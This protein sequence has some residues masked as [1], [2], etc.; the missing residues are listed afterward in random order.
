MIELKSPKNGQI[1]ELMTETQIKFIES[2]RTNSAAADFNYLDLKKGDSDNSLPQNVKFEW[3]ATVEG[4]VQIS[5]NEGFE[6]YYEKAGF[7]S[8]EV[9]NLKCATRYFW[10]VVCENEVSD[11]YCFDTNE[12][13]PRFMKVDGITNVRDCGGWRTVSG[14]RIKQGLLY[15][16]SEMNSHVT[17]T[18]AGIETMRKD[19]KI[20]FVIDFRSTEN[21]FVEDVYKKGYLNISV[22]PYCDWFRQPNSIIKN[23]FEILVNEENYPVYYH[24]WGGADRTGT[25]AFILGALLGQYREDLIGDYEITSLSIWGDR[26]RNIERVQEFIAEFDSFE[27]STMSEKAENY[28]LSCGISKAQ[29]DKFKE[30]MLS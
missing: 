3:T 17:I 24:C 18:D 13:C 6:S 19:M 16:G 4:V 2:D 5:E 26:S 30:I 14:R 22:R 1:V 20:N 25:L 23:I 12:R 27:G 15:R 28:M 10:R 9:Y 7:N 29:I 8:C 11:V 21:E